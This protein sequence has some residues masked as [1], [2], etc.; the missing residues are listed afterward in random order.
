[1]VSEAT[2]VPA[3]EAAPGVNRRAEVRTALDAPV[4]LYCTGKIVRGRTRDISA[5]GVRIAV[6]SDAPISPGETARIRV[7]IADQ[8]VVAEFEVLRRSS[9]DASG[10]VELACRFLTMREDQRRGL[11]RLCQ[12]L[13]R[14]STFD[15]VDDTAAPTMRHVARSLAVRLDRA[16][17]H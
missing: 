7:T 4:T 9:P 14:L 10:K 13:M 5:G 11:R 17:A 12:Q 15:D 8:D 3:P 1:M 6:A 2:G 16:G